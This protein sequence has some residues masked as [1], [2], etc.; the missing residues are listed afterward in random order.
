[1]FPGN[2]ARELQD[3]GGNLTGFGILQWLAARWTFRTSNK[4]GL[5][6]H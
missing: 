6:N 1:M 4:V 3:L 2:G 5:K